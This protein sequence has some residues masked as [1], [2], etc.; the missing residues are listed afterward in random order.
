MYMYRVECLTTDDYDRLMRIRDTGSSKVRM[1]HELVVL[2]ERKK[3]YDQ[4]RKALEDSKVQHSGHEDLLNLIMEKEIE[5]ASEE[6]TPKPPTL[7][8]NTDEDAPLEDFREG[9]YPPPGQL[10]NPPTSADAITQNTTA[11]QVSA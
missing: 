7:I 9:P 5:A 3:F 1:C 2:I 4:F 8:V 6:P 11:N 10:I